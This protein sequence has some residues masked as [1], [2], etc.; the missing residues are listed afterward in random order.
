MKIIFRKYVEKQNEIIGKVV[1]VHKIAHAV[2][3]LFS[4]HLHSIKFNATLS[5]CAAL[6]NFAATASHQQ[7]DIVRGHG[8]QASQTGRGATLLWH[9]LAAD[10][11]E[12]AVRPAL[13]IL[14]TH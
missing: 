6:R 11:L 13:G 9:D 1:K 12:I 8:K 2:F 7:L 5:C 4:C 3:T 10:W 14:S